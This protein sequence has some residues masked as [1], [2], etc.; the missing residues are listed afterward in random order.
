M[1]V[2]LFGQSSKQKPFE[3]YRWQIGLPLKIGLSLRFFAA[4]HREYSS[5]SDA[6]QVEIVFEFTSTFFLGYDVPELLRLRFLCCFVE[7]IESSSESLSEDISGSRACER[8]ESL[9]K[10]NVDKPQKF[11]N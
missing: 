5:L 8:K 4:K 2:I 1:C 10:K 7:D 9:P 6:N 11:F 3:W